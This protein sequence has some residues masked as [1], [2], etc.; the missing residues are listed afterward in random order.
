MATKRI[1]VIEDEK[2]IL[3]MISI[4]LVREGY[5]VTC[6][7]NGAEGCAEL[8]NGDYDL[9]LSDNCLPDCLGSDLIRKLQGRPEHY[10]LKTVLMTG[11]DMDAFDDDL[12]ADG[13][14]C[15]P[16]AMKELILLARTLLQELPHTQPLVA[17]TEQ[18]TGAWELHT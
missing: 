9:L 4:N 5:R 12:I 2:D 15:K 11:A 14:L 1:L 16:F 18:C 10:K 6:V 7:R 3:D 13:L 17:H 8:L